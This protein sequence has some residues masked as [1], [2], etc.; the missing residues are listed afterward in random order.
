M[1]I[2][3]EYPFRMVEHTWFNIAMKYLNPQYVFIG[4]KTNRAE[5]KVYEYKK[6]LLTKALFKLVSML[7]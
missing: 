7:I 5:C 2:V 4:R 1:N 6:E 3:H